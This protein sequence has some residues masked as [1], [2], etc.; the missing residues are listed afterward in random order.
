M[1]Q[2]VR[3]LERK[4]RQKDKL[5]AHLEHVVINLLNGQLSGS[6]SA[7]NKET[8]QGPTVNTEVESS[9][10]LSVGLD[11][12]KL[13]KTVTQQVDCSALGD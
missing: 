7:V 9:T 5:I 11:P 6:R 8:V 2:K 12:L 3:A 13:N 10:P 4:S 1:K